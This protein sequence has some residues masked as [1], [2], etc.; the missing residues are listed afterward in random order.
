MWRKISA[1]TT[2]IKPRRTNWIPIAAAI[3]IVGFTIAFALSWNRNNI[4]QANKLILADGTIVWLKDHAAWI[5]RS[6]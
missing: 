2:D 5:I 3:A 1:K 6:Y 4:T